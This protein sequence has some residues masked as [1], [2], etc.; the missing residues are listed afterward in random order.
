MK[1]FL[2]KRLL[3]IL[4][5]V[6][7]YIVT[8]YAQ[9]NP[10][11]TEQVY[12]QSVYPVLSTAVGFLPSLVGFSAAEWLV[13]LFLL[14][15]LGYI[16]YY[17]RKVIISKDGRGMAAYRGVAGATA[18]FC[19]MYFVST[20]L[21]GLNY[22]RYTFTY[23]TGYYVEQSS[24]EELEQLCTSLAGDIGRVRE[25]LGE[26]T[27]LFAPGPVDFDYYAQRSVLAMQMLA[28]QY[29][30]LDRSLYSTPKPV[31]M[32]ELMS[33]AGIVGVFFPF[34]L[35]SNINVNVPFFRLP[36]TMAHELAHQCGFMR[37]DEANFIAYLACKRLDEP[38]ILYSGLFLAFDH[39]IS[40]LEE[41]D[42]ELASE[43]MSGLSQAVLRDMVQREQF[44]TQYEGIISNVSNIVN[45][46]YLKVNNQMD[47]VY[48]YYRMVDLLLA[49]QRA[50][51]GQLAGAQGA[52][53]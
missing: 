13:A 16:V 35:E 47:G 21:G 49:E 53:R 33:H 10:H 29:P 48:S 42:P 52:V 44:W 38:M 26:D 18:I 11:W 46:I 50:A 32:S 14:F 6:A 25:Q 37:E 8:K 15:C 4:L 19:M 17:V 3:F 1:K 43:I 2:L 7:A 41:V 5:G 20:A 28:E 27:D 30:T 40:A 36:A 22:H 51:V 23:Y 9:Y 39:S 45:D 12:S 31:V 34:T 24:V